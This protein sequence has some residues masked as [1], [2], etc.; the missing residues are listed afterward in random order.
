[1][2]KKQ[3]VDLLVDKLI[4]KIL[5]VEPGTEEYSRLLGNLDQLLKAKG[6]TTKIDP[7]TLVTALSSL[8]GIGLILNFERLGVL[9]SKATSFVLKG[10]V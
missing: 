1:M 5:K 8:I 2:L 3:R 6:Y 10:R 4:S 7:N 9:T